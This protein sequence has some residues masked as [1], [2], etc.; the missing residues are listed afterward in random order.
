MKALKRNR[1][2]G[3]ER[4]GQKISKET[5]EKKDPLGIREKRLHTITSPPAFGGNYLKD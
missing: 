4:G 3:R 1:G 5:N 2:I